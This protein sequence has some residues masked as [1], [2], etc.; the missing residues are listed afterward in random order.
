MLNSFVN[1]CTY[2]KENLSTIMPKTVAIKSRTAS[3]NDKEIWPQK[4]Q[5]VMKMGSI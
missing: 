3:E 5:T 4:L 1:N 2:I